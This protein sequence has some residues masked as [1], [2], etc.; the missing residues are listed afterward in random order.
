MGGDTMLA[1]ASKADA[2]V[3]MFQRTS[4]LSSDD[5]ILLRGSADEK[6]SFYRHLKAQILPARGYRT[7]LTLS[8]WFLIL[9]SLAV[10]GTAYNSANNILFLSLSLMLSALIFSGLLTVIN[11]KGLSWV[12]SLPAELR[13][14]SLSMIGICVRNRKRIFPSFGV[15]FR[16]R[17]LKE[18]GKKAIWTHRAIAP[19][20]EQTLLLPIRP[21]KRGPLKLEIS[22]LESS[23]PF[24]FIRKQIG[25]IRQHTLW[26]WPERISYV[27]NPLH[28]GKKHLPGT[29]KT[30][31]GQ[32][33][34]LVNIR[35]YQ[36]GDPLRMMH[37]KASAR[38]GNLMVR[39]VTDQADDAY[40]LK[41]N[42]CTTVWRTQPLFEQYCSLLASLAEDLFQVNRLQGYAIDNELSTK[43]RT[44][45]DLHILLNRLARLQLGENNNRAE[46]HREFEWIYAEPDV[47]GSGLVIYVG[48]EPAG[49]II[50]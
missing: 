16:I 23:F 24:N 49:R 14:G 22:G 8:G 4:T 11:F 30:K 44:K 37:W 18:I 2:K 19:K 21:I 45:G 35:S 9:L 46:Q 29:M 34:D 47:N 25:G 13:V 6:W 43:V 48:I 5:A 36:P 39:Q 28:F 32:G 17:G 12:I 41:I 3:N 42:T 33:D 31:I 1:P 20:G 26:V 40:Y 7:H 50:D 15:G 10:G 27:F 38:V